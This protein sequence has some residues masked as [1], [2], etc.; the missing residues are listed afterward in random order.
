ML[1]V[2]LTQVKSYVPLRDNIIDEIATDSTGYSAPA[3]TPRSN[4]SH[5][6]HMYVTNLTSWYAIHYLITHHR[7]F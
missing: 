4:N 7:V 3:P 1:F 5:H 6:T 2:F